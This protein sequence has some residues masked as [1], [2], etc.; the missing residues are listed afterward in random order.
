MSLC[1]HVCFCARLTWFACNVS[2][3]KW[4]LSLTTEN[5]NTINV[6]PYFMNHKA[7][8]F[9]EAPLKCFHAENIS[10]DVARYLR[11]LPKRVVTCCHLVASAP[12]ALCSHVLCVQLETRQCWWRYAASASPK[13]K[14][15]N[16]R[17]WNNLLT[18]AALRETSQYLPKMQPIT[19]GS[20]RD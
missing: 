2:C 10:Q 13:T 11:P 15:T 17:T 9:N 19:T 3:L 20:V 6:V 8:G 16:S 7:Q 14:D 4:T 1:V 18:A 5:F 12:E